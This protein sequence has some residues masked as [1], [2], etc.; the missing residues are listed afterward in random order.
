MD[1]SHV[2]GDFWNELLNMR[3]YKHDTLTVLEQT[4]LPTNK[5]KRYK[6]PCTDCSVALSTFIKIKRLSSFASAL[7]LFMT[8]SR[9]G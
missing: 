9:T 4:D 7:I 2:S 8:L 3:N 6:E 5:L 1:A